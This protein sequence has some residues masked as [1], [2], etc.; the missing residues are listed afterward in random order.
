MIKFNIPQKIIFFG[1]GNLLLEF[2]KLS[3]LSKIPVYVFTERRHLKEMFKNKS[4]EEILIKNKIKFSC[5]NKKNFISKLKSEY[6]K[7]SFGITYRFGFI[8]DENIIKKFKN[9]LINIHSQILPNFRGKGGFTWNILSQDNRIGSTAHLISPKID[10]GPIVLSLK[11][12]IKIKNKNYD[13]IE[14]RVLQI[15]IKLLKILIKKILTKSNFEIKKISQNDSFY[16]PPINCKKNAWVDL[17]W[18]MENIKDFINGFSRKYGGGISYVGKKK[19]WLINARSELKNKLFHPF[20]IGIVYKI[21]NNRI[22]IIS[23]DGSFSCKYFWK[24]K[25]R[26]KLGAKIFTPN[27][28]LEKSLQLF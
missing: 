6:T 7:G 13:D 3:K 26:I 21:I 23:R 28:I 19:V 15:D 25:K 11:Q 8:F 14:K 17:N 5:V 22:F 24:Q 27:K 12:N 4:L 18:S 20:Q 16:F 2:I 1:G 9:R 10:K